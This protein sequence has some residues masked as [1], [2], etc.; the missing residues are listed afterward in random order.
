MVLEVYVQN[1]FWKTVTI[2]GDSYQFSQIVEMVYEGIDSGEI[3]H[4]TKSDGL[5]IE[6]KPVVN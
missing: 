5:A 4:V 3:T 6:A 2:P 1:I